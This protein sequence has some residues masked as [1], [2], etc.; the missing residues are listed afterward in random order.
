MNTL[1]LRL[2]NYVFSLCIDTLHSD[3]VES[4]S[5][6]LSVFLDADLYHG[7]LEGRGYHVVASVD[8]R[9]D[10]YRLD[11]DVLVAGEGHV[12]ADGAV[13]EE[14]RPDHQIGESSS[15]GGEHQNEGAQ[16]DVPHQLASSKHEGLDAG[17]FD[18][19]Y[20]CLLSIEQS[21]KTYVESN[22][23]T[24]ES[25]VDCSASD[26]AHGRRIGSD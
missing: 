11:R 23:K 15:K 20:A 26:R 3:D 22:N 17:R 5:N 19:I 12:E 18:N 21:Q 2:S 9:A 7:P 6:G 24:K 16:D 13:G 4:N 14:E 8:D 25:N 1:R 10:E